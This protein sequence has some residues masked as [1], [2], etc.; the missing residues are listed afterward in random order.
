ML[1]GQLMFDG[2]AMGLVFV[3]L[4]TGLV[5]IASV[6]RIL[7][8]A[9]GMFYTIGAYATWWIM[10]TLTLPYF[11]SLILAVIFA[12]AIGML[13]QLALFNPLMKKE[14]GFL[15]TL[16][17]SMG[18]LNILSQGDLLVFGTVARSIPTVFPGVL[19]ISSLNMPV[20]KMALIIIGVV[21]TLLLFFVYE[22]T[23][24]GRAM[25]TVAFLPEVASLQGINVNRIYILTLGLGTAIAGIAGA[26]LAPTYGINPA[27]G[28]NI[29]WTVLLMSMLGGMDSLLGAVV[30]GV[31]IGQLLSFGQFYIG[32]AIQI[33]IFVVIG[34]VLY[35]RPNGLLGRGINIGV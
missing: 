3:L 15:A 5:L 23:G 22:K 4:A 13:C 7:F 11:A 14:G 30:G 34:V 32:S 24:F 17:A 33:I 21:V 6:N 9:Y 2:L 26:I 25:R 18:L 20:A 29:L 8:M 31:V 10:H 19:H 1:A 12:A 27:M 16:I 35:F 28:N